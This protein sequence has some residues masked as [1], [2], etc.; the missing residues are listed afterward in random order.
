MNV[1]HC[2]SLLL[3]DFFSVLVALDPAKTNKLTTTISIL[4]TTINEWIIMYVE[5]RKVAM[6][7]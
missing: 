1:K 4:A 2:D 7:G 3:T 5:G 6:F